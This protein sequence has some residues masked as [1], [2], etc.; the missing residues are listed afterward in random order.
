[1][2]LKSCRVLVTPRS[3]GLNDP[4]LRSVLEETVGEVIYRGRIHTS[5]ELQELL[6]GCHG[7]I[8]GLDEIDRAAIEAATELK[9]IARYGV[10]VD[11]VDLAAARE[12]GIVVTNTPGANAG[13]VAELT[14]GLMLAL[15]RSIPQANAALRAG[16]ATRVEGFS[17]EGKTVGLLGLGAIGKQVARRLQAFGCTVLAY[18]PVPD[19]SFAERYGVML[20]SQDEVVARSDFLSL[21]LPALPET[22]GMVNATFLAQM[23][24][25]AFLINTARGELIDEAALLEALRSGH[26]RGAALDVFATEPPPPDHP[27]LALPQVIATPHIGAHT[28]GA[29]NMMGWMAL[30]DCLAVLRGEEPAHRVV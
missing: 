18:D 12:R 22:Y 6:P 30:R 9:V 15:A 19:R 28:D 20:C 24:P 2:E 14:I 29:M 1:M 8:A 25:G 17:L 23:K 5:Q 7:F 26:L 27:L 21:H 10:G 4:R 13:A 3:Y 16:T 11:N